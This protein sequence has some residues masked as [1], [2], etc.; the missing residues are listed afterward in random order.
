MALLSFR[1][2]GTPSLPAQGEQRRSS[3]FNIRRGNPAL[4]PSPTM[5]HDGNQRRRWRLVG[6][7]LRFKHSS[8]REAGCKRSRESL[9]AL[10]HIPSDLTVIETR[11]R[12]RLAG[13]GRLEK[14]PSCCLA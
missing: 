10:C 11:G 5:H 14:R 12:R 4:N 8:G 1:G 9:L 7:D 13:M 3:Y 2:I 6:T